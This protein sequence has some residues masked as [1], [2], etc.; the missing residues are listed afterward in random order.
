MLAH[1]ESPL[2]VLEQANYVG[3]TRGMLEWVKNYKNEYGRIASNSRVFIETNFALEK[4]IEVELMTY[5]N[6]LVIK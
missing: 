2:P 5:Y 4:V 1:P 3:S 6:F